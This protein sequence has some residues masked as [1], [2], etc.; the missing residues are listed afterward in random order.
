[1]PY[2]TVKFAAVSIHSGKDIPHKINSPFVRRH[3]DFHRL[4][5]N[6]KNLNKVTGNLGNFIDEFIF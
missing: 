3:G 5:F 6:E 1:V 4:S 2:I